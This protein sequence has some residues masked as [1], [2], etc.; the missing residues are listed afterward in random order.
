[1]MSAKFKFTGMAYCEKQN[2]FVVVYA[3]KFQSNKGTSKMSKEES[4][5]AELKLG[6]EKEKK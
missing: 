2:M 6:F 3:E 1:M 4:S 5:C